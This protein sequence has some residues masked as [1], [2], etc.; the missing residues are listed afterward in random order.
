MKKL[1]IYY[2]VIQVVFL[3][4]VMRQKRQKKQD[5]KKK[6]RDRIVFDSD[7]QDKMIIS[8]PCLVFMDKTL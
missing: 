2:L 7:V 1:D 4:I 8:L 5:K 3:V 6:N